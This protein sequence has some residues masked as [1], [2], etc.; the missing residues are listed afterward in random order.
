MMILLIIFILMVLFMIWCMCDVSG[1]CS[2][3]EEENKNKKG[4]DDGKN[5]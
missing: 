2:R 3:W 5:I 1:D 4:D